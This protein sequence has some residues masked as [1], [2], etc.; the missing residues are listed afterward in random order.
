MN[1]SGEVKILLDC[2]V[3]NTDVHQAG[4]CKGIFCLEKTMDYGESTCLA[5]ARHR[6]EYVASSNIS[7]IAAYCK[8][9]GIVYF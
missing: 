2:D 4:D 5:V 7:Q 6:K 9:H 1:W 3:S 8:T